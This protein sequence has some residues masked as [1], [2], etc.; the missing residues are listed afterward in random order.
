MGSAALLDDI[1]EALAELSAADAP[2]L[3]R[4]D[5]LRLIADK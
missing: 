3:T 4:D 1:R 5:A 2:V